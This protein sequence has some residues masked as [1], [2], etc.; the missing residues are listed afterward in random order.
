MHPESGLTGP[1]WLS[2]AGGG[3]GQ[4][5]LP[6]SFFFRCPSVQWTLTFPQP[7]R[8]LVRS[9]TALL[10]LTS[11]RKAGN[12][13][14]TVVRG[15][16][17]KMDV[18][19][20]HVPKF[21]NH[22]KPIGEY[23]F[24][25]FPPM[26]LLGLADCLRQN[27]RSTEIIHL[28]VERQK[29]GEIDLE[30]I[31]SERNPDIVGLDLHWHFQAYDVIEVAKRIK[32]IRP[33]I[34]VLLGGFT[35]TVFA[36]EILKSYEC[37]DFVIR[38]ESEVPILDLHRQYCS[39]R[40]YDC[41]ANLAYRSGGTVR[42][43]PISYL[44]DERMLNSLS[45]TDFTLL[46]DYPLFVESFSR[47]MN[48]PSLSE[49]MQRRIFRNRKGYPVFL[50]RGCPHACDYCG[51]GRE[52]HIH[53]NSR[54][55]LSLRSVEAVAA[56]LED[57]QRFGFDFVFLSYDPLPCT[58]AEQFYLALFE[59]V[60]KR[61]LS[62]AFEIERWQL[63]TRKFIQ[64]VRDTLPKGSMISL[65]L[66]SS[67]ERVRKK[68]G[69]FFF[70]N[71]SVEECLAMMD[72]E[73]VDCL[74]F[75]AIGLPFETAEDLEET[76]RYQKYLRSRFK[77]VKLMTFVIEIEPG[78]RL[79]DHPDSFEAKLHRST[80]ADYYHYHSLPSQNHFLESGYDRKDCP[81]PGEVAEAFCTQFCPRAKVRGVLAPL[82]C[83]MMS[84][85]WRSGIIHLA[86]RILQPQ[87]SRT[88][89]GVPALAPLPRGSRIPI[90][91][92]DVLAP[93]AASPSG[94]GARFRHSDSAPQ[95][96]EPPLV[97]IS[98]KEDLMNRT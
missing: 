27:G 40:A 54:T 88:P 2:S 42:L 58:R 16:S 46:K 19:F 70:S 60:K 32:R 82:M 53:I 11:R 29:Q 85:I 15:Q 97:K 56:S 25:L 65:T 96:V 8:L 71:Q 72:E 7:P 87:S 47:Y 69:L 3:S 83:N 92:G 74:L 43:N 36:E 68:N 57:I 23:S 24:I 45:F 1:P 64:A 10:R 26:G 94:A 81:K 78:S 77:R 62:L 35:A 84:L 4:S 55:R 33:D 67:S 17:S 80:F 50:G 95:P 44:A 9:G 38:G 34:A 49:A 52:S 28:G 13:R 75:F 30:R 89:H 76:A 61:G 63:P 90:P 6:G 51:G 93:E 73:G 14:E 12:S 18:L 79:N 86:D 31:L 98:T 39:E 21:N 66:N 20:L 41:V 59:Q 37:V 5:P 48:I 91:D 22:Y